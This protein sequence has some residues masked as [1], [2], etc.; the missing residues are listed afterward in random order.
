MF[1]VLELNYGRNHDFYNLIIVCTIGYMIIL[2]AFLI[3]II[4]DED[5]PKIFTLLIFFTGGILNIVAGII[6]FIWRSDS[7]YENDR[8]TLLALGL[9]TIICGCLMIVDM[10]LLVLNK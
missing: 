1:V 7:H 4:M 2:L 6:C 9:M 5:I 8:G 10:I 3:S